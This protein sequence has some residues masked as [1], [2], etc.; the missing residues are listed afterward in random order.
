MSK[1]RDNDLYESVFFGPTYSERQPVTKG[2]S[3]TEKVVTSGR[4]SDG[5]WQL[6]ALLR[7]KPA[8]PE[9][10]PGSATNQ[11]VPLWEEELF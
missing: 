9:Q 5:Y 10:E 8:G 6:Y 3:P 2:V 7:G 1:E 11:K 4:S